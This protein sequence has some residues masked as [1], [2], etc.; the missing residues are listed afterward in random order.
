MNISDSGS[1]DLQ[2]HFQTR[3]YNHYQS[4]YLCHLHRNRVFLIAEHNSIQVPI[5]EYK[6]LVPQYNVALRVRIK[7][8]RSNYSTTFGYVQ[9]K[10]NTFFCKY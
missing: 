10:A 8:K 4:I 9:G 6:Q 3:Y 1:T 5:I 2:H 7:N